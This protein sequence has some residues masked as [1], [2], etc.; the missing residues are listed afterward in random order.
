MGVS[1]SGKSLVGAA[2]AQAMGAE[3]AEGDSYHPP[4]NIARM[5]SGQALRD[6]DRWGWLDAIANE[7]ARTDRSRGALVVTCS[8]LKRAYRDRLRLASRH[9]LFVYLDVARDVAAARVANRKGHFMPASLIDSQFADLEP[10]AAEEGA[11]TV[12]A[13]LDAAGIGRLLVQT[14]RDR[15][16]VSPP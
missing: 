3:F 11:L 13:T 5:A 4:E 1:G 14:L 15:L 8:A 6:Q 2:L 7:I 12:D 10:P 16:P 9:V